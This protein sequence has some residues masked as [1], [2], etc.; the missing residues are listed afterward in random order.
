MLCNSRGVASGGSI[1][2]NGHI[3]VVQHAHPNNIN[4]NFVSPQLTNGQSFILIDLSD[5]AN[6]KHTLTNYI[7]IEG[8]DIDADASNNAEFLVQ[9]GFLENVD[10][11]NGDFIEID[12]YN[13]IKQEDRF[14]SLVKYNY[15]N[16]WRCRSESVVSSVKL[17]NN[18]GYRTSLN[19]ATT[20]NPS[21]INTPPGNGDLI[22]RTTITAGTVDLK[23]G[24]SYHTH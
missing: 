16:M 10:G 4:V 7:H 19:L 15:P 20:L 8:M 2:S 11:T 17:L 12:R 3:G 1:D 22:L 14:L 24:I 9:I 5:T 6:Y 13:K 18:T 23:I 21:S